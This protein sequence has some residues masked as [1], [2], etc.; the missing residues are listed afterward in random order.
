MNEKV[1]LDNEYLRLEKYSNG[2]YVIKTYS[3]I[4]K[5]DGEVIL[6]KEDIERIYFTMKLNEVK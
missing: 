1:L 3:S 4:G 6:L 2:N 5:Y